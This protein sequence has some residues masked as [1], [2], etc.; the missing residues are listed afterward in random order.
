MRTRFDEQRSRSYPKT[1]RLLRHAA[2]RTLDC[3]F[4]T[5][6]ILK[7]IASGGHAADPSG[8]ATE[9]VPAAT[10]EG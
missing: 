3:R 4:P 8:A 9:R 6:V 5:A 1:D 10:A 2:P 7:R